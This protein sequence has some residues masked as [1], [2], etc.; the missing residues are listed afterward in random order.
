MKNTKKKLITGML[1]ALF[2]QLGWADNPIFQTY[3]S[4]DPAPM[5]LGDTLFVYSGN[6]QGGS[7]FTMNGW[8]VS[9]TT[10]M[11]NWTD[12]G[13]IIF[14]HN[15]I[16]YA[17]E[18][19][20]WA[21]QC[22][23]RNGKFYYYVTVEASDGG[24]GR[25]INVG[26]AD[27]PEGPFKDALGKHLAGPNW[28]YI[29]PTVFIDD[30]D[31][32]YLYWGNPKLYYAKLNK[33]MI[34]F[35][36]GIHVTDMSRG[37]APN[38]EGSKYTEGPWIHKHDGKYYM[39]YASHGIP[40][41]ISYS[42][43]NSPTGPWEWKGII[44]GNSGSSFTN[45]SGVIDFKGRSFIFYHNGDLP[46]GG[47]YNRSTAVEEFTY[48]ADGTIPH[49][50]MTKIGVKK[51]IH[52]LDPFVRVEAETKA[53]SYGLEAGQN[54]N[55]VYM[56][57]IHNKDYIKVRCV[58][59]GDAGADFFTASVS[60]KNDASIEI[61]VDKQDGEL[62]GTLKISNTNG[63]WKEIEC[64]VTNIVGEHDLFFVFKGADRTELFDF[65]Y[66]YFTSNAVIVPQS[67]YNGEMHSI[68]GK[69]EFED[70][71]EGGQNRAYY[72][73]DMENQGEQYR[74]D[75][76][77]IVTVLP[78]NDPAEG[79]AIGYTSEGEWME[80]SVNIKETREYEFETRVAC[81]LNTSGIQLY[82]DN[83]EI[84]QNIEVPNTED[85][86]T[87]TIVKGK[88]TT[89][90]SEGEHIL[91]VM[92]TGAYA[93]LDWIRFL[94]NGDE[95]QTIELKNNPL[96]FPLSVNIYSIDGRFLGTTILSSAYTQEISQQLHDAGYATGTYLMKGQNFNRVVIC[97]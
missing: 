52:L 33:D 37:F 91:K 44:L 74:N 77:D 21:S 35:D 67:L 51:P 15:D 57:K 13:T 16:P 46:G 11:V 17:K 84:S 85:W 25:A 1:F 82:L 96:H 41:S 40:E 68:P 50:E 61:H 45:H 42:M 64:E 20:D 23:P 86:D 7:F 93:N 22:I 24:G 38:G 49:V 47:G 14:S 43:S 78:E 69:I 71:D 56:T 53:F 76:V 10:D 72:D 26:V 60:S 12:R 36:G 9:S 31:Q 83:K 5:V 90:L 19:G 3:Y 88:T 54:N 32:A 18:A 28:D 87:Y 30:D 6:D 95:T 80:Y 55:G 27:R 59:F 39:I 70:Y 34:S 73:E 65:D 94:G 4:P 66:W 81:G 62:I 89:E 29:D 8:R 58:D 2:T 63:A 97:K 48:N 75:R 92:L 79:Y